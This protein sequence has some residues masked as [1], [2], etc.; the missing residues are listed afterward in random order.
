[1]PDPFHENP[2]PASEPAR[3]EPARA[4]PARA[5]P[6]RAEPARAGP[7]RAEPAQ[8]EE[9]WLKALLDRS[10]ARTSQPSEQPERINRKSAQVSRELRQIAGQLS[11]SI[12]Q[13]AAQ[14]DRVLEMANQ[15]EAETARPQVRPIP[16]RES[17]PDLSDMA[18]RLSAALRRGNRDESAVLFEERTARLEQDLR[19]VAVRASEQARSIATETARDVML[20]VS[21][22][23]PIGASAADSVSAETR[24]NLNVGQLP[25]DV[26][27][28]LRD[29]QMDER[30]AHLDSLMQE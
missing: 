5:E 22:A 2:R 27:A 6:A 17:A 21:R 16:E 7:A 28:D 13:L 8:A 4:E 23:I 19:D 3:A 24:R 14:L 10:E 30:H 15:A 26:V 18:Q 20:G 1:M 29:A 11:R 25:N 12:Q 9:G